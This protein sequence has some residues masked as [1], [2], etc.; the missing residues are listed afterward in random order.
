MKKQG[1]GGF[2]GAEGEAE[3]GRRRLVLAVVVLVGEFLAT[4]KRAG[5]STKTGVYGN[6]HKAP[7]TQ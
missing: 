5:H 2:G 6:T 7:Q 4:L 1:K 3:E